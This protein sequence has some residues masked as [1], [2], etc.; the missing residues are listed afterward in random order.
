MD[1]VEPVSEVLKPIYGL[2]VLDLLCAGVPRT[3]F[4][5]PR[6]ISSPIP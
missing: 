5:A 6:A 2:L 1:Y 4:R 3:N